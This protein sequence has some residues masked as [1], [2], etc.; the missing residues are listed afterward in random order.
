MF[1]EMPSLFTEGRSEVET[2]DVYFLLVWQSNSDSK[3]IS[4]CVLLVLCHNINS[5]PFKTALA[6]RLIV[7]TRFQTPPE[8]FQ[9]KFSEEMTMRQQRVNSTTGVLQCTN[10]INFVSFTQQQKHHQPIWFIYWFRPLFCLAKMT[11]QMAWWFIT[12]AYFCWLPSFNF[13]SLKLAK[14]DKWTSP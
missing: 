1:L 11:V 13:I 4:F 12:V 10:I 14:V 7:S 3:W 5:E 2:H 9:K 8:I 6:V